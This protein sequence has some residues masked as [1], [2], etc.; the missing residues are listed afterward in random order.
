VVRTVC[1]SSPGAVPYNFY[2]P[3]LLWSILPETDI[4]Q[5]PFN[6]STSGTT[7]TEPKFEVFKLNADA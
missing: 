4:F 3:V 7:I 1:T 5:F 2:G 6:S